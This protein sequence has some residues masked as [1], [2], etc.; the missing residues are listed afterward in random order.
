MASKRLERSADLTIL[1]LLVPDSARWCT[2]VKR[3]VEASRLEN[4][5]VSVTLDK[6]DHVALEKQANGHSSRLSMMYM[7]D[8]AI[9]HLLIQAQVPHMYLD[10]EDP[11]QSWG[12]N[13]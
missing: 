8:Y 6:A 2:M 9:R 3:T 10:L 4:R 12:R 1:F 11:L 13:G 5:R 7:L